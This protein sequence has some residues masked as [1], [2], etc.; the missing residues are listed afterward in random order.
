MISIGDA[1]STS[2]RRVSAEK[3]FWNC[4][5]TLTIM[6]II[7]LTHLPFRV[8]FFKQRSQH[9]ILQIDRDFHRKLW[10]LSVMGFGVVM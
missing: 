10:G 6:I 1:W 9:L 7:N 2:Y 8:Y 5:K 4:L 3:V